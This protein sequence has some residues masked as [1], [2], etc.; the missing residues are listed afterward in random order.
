LLSHQPELADEEYDKK[1]D[2]EETE[3]SECGTCMA[4][5]SSRGS[6]YPVY[7]KAKT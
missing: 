2:I 6:L 1:S 7:P 4:E 3:T 5:P